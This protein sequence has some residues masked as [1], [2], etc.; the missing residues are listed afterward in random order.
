MWSLKDKPKENTISNTTPR[1]KEID[2]QQLLL[3]LRTNTSINT[4][5]KVTS[6]N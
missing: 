2:V 6:K 1:K 5:L 3:A 4:R